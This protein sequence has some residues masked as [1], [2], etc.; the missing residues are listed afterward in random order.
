MSEGGRH[1]LRGRWRGPGSRAGELSGTEAHTLPLPCLHHA[2]VPPV[3]VPLQGTPGGEVED[4]CEAAMETL[5]PSAA[6]AHPA[7]FAPAHQLV[8]T[9]S[10]PRSAAPAQAAQRGAPAS[11]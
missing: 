6:L 5:A 9:Q 7:A 11:Q 4:G 8:R 1:A 10:R 2:A 3:V